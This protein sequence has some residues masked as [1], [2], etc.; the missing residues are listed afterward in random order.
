MAAAT[1]VNVRQGNDSFR[2]VISD[3]W[4]VAATLDAG[5]LVD[6]AGESDTVAVP[7]VLLGDVIMGISVG[8]SLV[9]MSVTA[10]VSAADVVTV[11]IQ[12]ESGSTV[13]LASA[14]I[15]ILIGRLI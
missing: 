5:S 7:G 9:G 15:K 1:A 10:Y 6:G 3:T 14:T 11:R 13:D 2:G 12:N 8:V 4:S